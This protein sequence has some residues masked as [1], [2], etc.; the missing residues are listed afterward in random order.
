MKRLFKLD[1]ENITR[2]NLR[3][4]SGIF[5]VIILIFVII[6]I[7]KYF[8]E[9]KTLQKN[10]KDHHVDLLKQK[11]KTDIEQLENNVRYRISINQENIKSYITEQTNLYYNFTETQYQHYKFDDKFSDNKILYFLKDDFS[12][13]FSKDSTGFS[14]IGYADQISIYKDGNLEVLAK[15]NW[16]EFKEKYKDEFF[17]KNK[18]MSLKNCFNEI[19]KDSIETF[20]SM[21]HHKALDFFVGKIYCHK[22]VREI[23]ESRIIDEINLSYGINSDNYI[24]VYRIINMEGGKGFARMIVNPNRLDLIGSLIDD[25]YQDVKGNTFRKKFMEDI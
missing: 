16:S 8:K 3:I 20:V 10:T 2:S 7:P 5:L 19:L 18:T 17:T 12:E 13:L 23:V 21:K 1:E 14:F 22:L 9:Y 15:F 6:Y 11:M 25:D 4:S 24:F